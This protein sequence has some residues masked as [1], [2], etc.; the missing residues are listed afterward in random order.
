MNMAV[1]NAVHDSHNVMSDFS[2]YTILLGH[3]LLF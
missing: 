3:I 2:Q 1:I